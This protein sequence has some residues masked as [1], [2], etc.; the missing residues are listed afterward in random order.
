[1]NVQG[2]IVMIGETNVIS[3]KFKKR[4]LVL[5]CGD[6]PQYLQNCI[7]EAHQDKVSILDDVKVGDY[8]NVDFNLHGRKWESPKGE[9]RYF[10]TLAVWKIASSATS[11]ITP[12]TVEGDLPF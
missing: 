3:D 5:E 9:T 4:D 6:N 11:D 2:K 1:M 8:V 7:F 12:D 10:N